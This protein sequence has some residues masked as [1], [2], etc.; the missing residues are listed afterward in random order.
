MNDLKQ[1]TDIIIT[2]ADKGGAVVIIDVQNYIK[3]ANKQL[4]NTQV[5]LTIEE[6]LTNKH[7]KMI[8]DLID[9]Y[10][11]EKLITF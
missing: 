9:R 7:N 3:E 10:I 1:R 5:Y 8:N 2:K 4:A 6:D 11:A